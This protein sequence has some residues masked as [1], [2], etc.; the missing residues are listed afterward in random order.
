VANT[1]SVLVPTLIQSLQRVLRQTGFIMNVPTLDASAA[2]AGLN[3]TI[4]LPATAAQATY[5]VS[6]GATPPALVDTTPTTVTMTLSQYKGSRFHVT[7]EDW[8]SLAA[9]GP[10]FRLRQ[11]DEAIAALLHEAAAYV[12]TDL[13]A[14]AGWALGTD[15]TAPLGSNPDIL[16]D[17]WKM[18]SDAKAPEMDRI[19]ALS[20]FDYASAGKLDQFQ[21]LNEAPQGTSFANARLGM[22]A[23]FN[24]GWDQAIGE[25]AVGTNDGNYLVDN[26]A[27]YAIGATAIT[28]DTGA[29]TILAG[30]V[31]SFAAQTERY[32]VAS[33]VGTTLTIRG[34]LRLAIANNDAVVVQAAH[35]SNIFAHRDAAVLAIR[36]PAEAPDGDAA[37]QVAIIPDPV[38]GI[39][40]R[41]AQ[42]KGY[43]ASQYE[44]SI[45]YGHKVRRSALLGKLIG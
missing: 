40:L 10:D 7:G 41:L 14:N 25:H 4:N 30:D 18:L 43:H 37:T 28:V 27:G 36:P 19:L 39:A 16:M 23:N 12:W 11:V 3:Q 42:Y 33:L 1:L 5:T 2:T 20:T 8:R 34:G 29:G 15:G 13:D 17:A 21:K 31:V 26:G 45:V 35:R 9:R 44:L 24:V 22:L 32:V 6:P 38:T